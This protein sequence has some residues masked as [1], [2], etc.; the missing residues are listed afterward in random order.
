MNKKTRILVNMAIAA[1]MTGKPT[2][3]GSGYMKRAMRALN[4][5][6]VDVENKTVNRNG[7]VVYTAKLPWRVLE[8]K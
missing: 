8:K 2:K 1:S 5:H 6:T 7:K 3:R 4:G